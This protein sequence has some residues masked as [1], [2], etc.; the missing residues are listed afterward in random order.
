MSLLFFKKGAE[1]L[2]E[3]RHLVKVQLSISHGHKDPRQ[4]V[5]VYNEDKSLFFERIAS[6][7]IKQ[8]MGGKLKKYF[9]AEVVE[10][11]FKLTNRERTT[12]PKW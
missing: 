7:E 4:R 2:L 3:G 11:N 1:S 9:W 12:Q 6:D 10:G 8:R 5:M